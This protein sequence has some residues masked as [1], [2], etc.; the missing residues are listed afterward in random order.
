M[1]NKLTDTQLVLL[2]AASQREDRYLTPPAGAR[3]GPARK[4]AAKLLE[5]GFVKE[6]RARKEAPVWRSD[7]E[8]KQ[9]FALKLTAAG[10]KVIAAE[11]DEGS[12]E[13]PRS[14]ERRGEGDCEPQTVETHGPDPIRDAEPDVV[15]SQPVAPRAGTKIASVIAML[16]KDEGATIDEIVA[17]TEWLP[18]TTR[19]ALTGLRKRGYAVASDRSDLTRN[20]IYRIACAESAPAETSDASVAVTANIGSSVAGSNPP[21]LKG[22]K[23]AARTG[24][25]A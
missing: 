23:A 13:A 22:R 19:A 9:S 20:T 6:L 25:A 4:A 8:T 12:E 3:L 16:K 17:A 10:L 21:G 7:E 2:S 24:R 11:A 14:A 15:P 18:H 1:S 5:A